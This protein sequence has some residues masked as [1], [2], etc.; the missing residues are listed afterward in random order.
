MTQQVCLVPYLHGLGGMVSFQGKFIQGLEKFNVEYTFDLAD[1]RNDAILVIGGTRQI[2]QLLKAKKHGVRIV[3]RLNGMNWLHRVEKT[4]IKSWVRG[5]TANM[6]LTFI[7]RSICDRI[8]YQSEFSR[9]WWED[10]HGKLEK[11]CRVIPNGIDLVSYTPKGEERPPADRYRLLMVEGHLSGHYSRGLDVATRLTMM[12]QKMHDKPV[13]LSIAGDVPETLKA[14]YQKNLPDL[15]I[16]W[17]GVIPQEQITALD[18]SAHLL[19]SADLNAACPN[20]VIEALACGLPVLAFDTGALS[21]LVQNGAGAVVP[22]GGNHWKLDPPDIPALA[23]AALPILE[24][25]ASFRKA[26]RRRA[27]EAFDLDDMTRAYLEVLL[28]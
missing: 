18:R 9:W 27:E 19:Y 4:P 26:A 10:R 5:E 7:R 15:M 12:L 13:E 8:I 23:Q 14:Q 17:V 24:H 16:N 6:L 1:P 2:P 3:Q 28:G 21:E 20:S 25:N 11:P 22:Y